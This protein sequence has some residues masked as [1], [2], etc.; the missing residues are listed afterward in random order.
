MRLTKK[1]IAELQKIRCTAGWSYER[2]R[3]EIGAKFSVQTL[4][5]AMTGRPIYYTTSFVLRQY[6][7]QH[8]SSHHATGGSAK[9]GGK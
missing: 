4:L 1:E 3:T 5:N 7:D 8:G 9:G 6:L 2:F